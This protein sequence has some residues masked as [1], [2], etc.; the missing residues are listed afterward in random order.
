MFGQLLNHCQAKRVWAR[1][2]WYL[3]NRLL[4]MV[5]ILT[6]AILFNL[7]LGQQPL[8]LARLDAKTRKES[9]SQKA[10]ELPSFQGKREVLR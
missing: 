8:Q 2:G 5:L 3:C 7:V 9:L 4:R 6:L 10:V 1:Y